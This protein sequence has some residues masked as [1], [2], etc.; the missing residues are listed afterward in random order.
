MSV[1]RPHAGVALKLLDPVDGVGEVCLRSPAVMSGYWGE[2]AP[3]AAAFTPDGFVRTGDLGWVDDA[4]RLRLV[5]RNKEMYVRGGYNVYPME[6]EAVLAEHPAV[7]SIAVVPRPDDVMGE[8]GVA[9]VVVRPGVPVPG[10]DSLRAFAADRLAAYKL[11]E[12][13][14]EVDVPAVDGDGEG[15]PARTGCAGGGLMQLDFTTDQ[16]DLRSSVRS[17]LEREWPIASVRSLVETGSRSGVDDLWKTMVSLDWPGLALSEAHGGVGLGFVELAVVAEELGRVVAAG[18]LLSTVT[19]FVPAVREVHDGP[20]LDGVATGARTGTLAVAEDG[21]WDLAAVAAEAI[22]TGIAFIVRGTKTHVFEA[23]S[24]DTIAVV[25]RLGDELALLTVAAGDADVR[26]VAPVDGSR[27]LCTVVLDETPAELVATAPVEAFERVLQEATVALALEM[28]GGCQAIFDTTLDYA[29]N[30]HQF[31]V[32]IGSFQ[33]VKH[34]LAN[35]AVALER[36][37]A[38]CYFAAATIAE[39]D[40]RR[41]LATSMAKAAAG[42]AQ[43]LVAQDGIQLL[44]GIGYTWEHDMQLYVK[45]VKCS[46]PLFGSAS[47]HRAKIADHLGL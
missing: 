2:P 30:R 21:R 11:P 34:K 23:D 5:G 46:E 19:Q 18:P 22:A 1:G 32:P 35:M 47:V 44:G 39:D 41:S 24:V 31:G 16:E 42:D 9:V 20:V 12:A 28:V 38:T 25:A 17:V 14:L 15:R 33:A 45:R 36:A 8:V 3:T 10:L 27:S 6:V 4:G 7:A 26:P 40:P 37:R 29:K 13:V 43:R